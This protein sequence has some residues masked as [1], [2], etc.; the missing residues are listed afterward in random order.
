MPAEQILG[1]TWMKNGLQVVE[2]ENLRVLPNGSLFISAAWNA[3]DEGDSLRRSGVEGN[4]S[5]VS[6]RSLGS[7]ASQIVLLRDSTLSQ[8]FQHPESQTVERKG[9]ARFECQIEGIPVPVISWQKDHV[10]VSLDPRFIVLPNGVLQIVDVQ[11]SDAGAYHCV[12]SN[13]AGRRHSANAIL[14]IVKGHQLPPMGDVTFAA[15]PENT[16]VAVGETA[17]LECMASADPVPFVSWIR[18]DGDPISTDVI[19]LGRTNLVI[20]YAQ[21]HHAG[22]YVCRANKPQTR[23]FVTAAAELRVLAPPSVSQAP[24]TISRTRASTARFVCRA[25]GEPTPNIHWMKNGEP[26]SSN[27]RVKMQSS[28]TLVINQIGMDDA[29]YYQCVA[30]NPLGMA[31]ATAQLAVIVR[32]GLP[33]SPKK[34]TAS[35]LSSTTV[36][37]SWERPEFNSEQIIGFSLHYQKAL[38][39]T[40]STEVH[41]LESDT[42]Y[43][44]KMGAKTV[45]G[46]GPYSNVKDVQT[47]QERF[48]DILD[49]HSVTGIIVGVCLGLLCIL[50]CMCAT[51]HNNKPRDS[52]PGLDSQAAGNHVYYLRNRQLPPPTLAP[53][54]SHELES[55]MSPL[56]K[57]APS[58]SADVTELPEVQGLVRG[59]FLEDS[60]SHIKRKSQVVR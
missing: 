52:V 59:S 18:E 49:V 50:F 54:D 10:A 19:V 48:S 25:E 53:S 60:A 15:A 46:S 20:P 16:T 2:E 38:G 45:V 8:F 31:C 22:V 40:F 27:G 7:V 3:L 5:C 26:L 6:H 41:G 43:F 4:Y 24:E 37:V 35:S 23:Q 1:V 11:E 12:A 29:G 21:P 36:L 47:L 55:L 56:P 58:P 32:E 42:R 39:N 34:V 17:V 33:S 9:V 30:E 57:D 28:G 14:S 51:F 44:F 13:W